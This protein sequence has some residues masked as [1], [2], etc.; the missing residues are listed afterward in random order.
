[1]TPPSNSNWRKDGILFKTNAPLNQWDISQSF[2]TASECEAVKSKIE[3]WPGEFTKK[4]A[5]GS[6]V[7]ANIWKYHRA[8]LRGERRS[9]PQIA[10]LFWELSPKSVTEFKSSRALGDSRRAAPPKASPELEKGPSPSTIAVLLRSD[11]EASDC[12]QFCAPPAQISGTAGSSQPTY[13]NL[14]SPSLA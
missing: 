13:R 7:H 8:A 1:M 5:N 6:R 9:A 10:R 4:H 3:F 2:D 14:E 12:A 11:G